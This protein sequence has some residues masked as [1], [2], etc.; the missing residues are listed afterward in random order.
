MFKTLDMKIQN[1]VNKTFALALIAVSVI[2]LTAIFSH[3]PGLIELQCSTQGCGVVID[4]R[5]PVK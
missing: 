1:A 4:G 3:Y 5:L 2:V